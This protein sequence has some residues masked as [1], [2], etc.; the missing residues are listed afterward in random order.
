MRMA[1][2]L[3]RRRNSLGEAA[4]RFYRLLAREVAI[5]GTDAAELVSVERRSD[6]S[7]QVGLVAQRNGR[8]GE[9]F[10]RRVFLP[11]E[12]S[13]LRIYM[14][15]SNDRAVI[16]GEWPGITVRL[17]GGAGDD[18]LID[19]SRTG[20]VKFYTDDG[21]SVEE[22]NRVKVDRRTYVLPPKKTPT[23]LPPR[24]WGQMY[25]GIPWGSFGP[26]AGLF[27]GGGAYPENAD[28][29]AMVEDALA[30][31]EGFSPA[32]YES[33]AI[34]VDPEDPTQTTVVEVEV[35]DWAFHEDEG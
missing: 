5:H 27:V 34:I 4:E 1:H 17:I 33:L 31:G 12:T 10:F 21:D 35:P 22:P 9:P 30:N 26:D 6:G 8:R 3:K 16:R 32:P 15:E 13:E 18:V 29:V 25:R 23:E 14:H 20:G 11:D 19:S 7:T 28:A 2:A 24:D